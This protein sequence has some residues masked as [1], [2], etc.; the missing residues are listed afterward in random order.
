VLYV[1]GRPGLIDQLKVVVARRGEIFLSHD[2]GIEE[3]LAT[4]PAL[5]SRADAAFFPMDRISHSAVGHV[6]KYCRDGHKP[7]MPLRSVSVASFVAAIGRRDVLKS[8]QL[9]Q[10]R[11]QG[12]A[13]AVPAANINPPK[14]NVIPEMGL[15]ESARRLVWLQSNAIRHR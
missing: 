3:N 9:A 7:F 8:P 4:L 2:G 11:I 5:I 1:G 15:R 10:A 12:A 6:K 13:L 14:E